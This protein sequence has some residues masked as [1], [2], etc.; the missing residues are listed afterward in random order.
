MSILT[1]IK[2]VFSEKPSTDFKKSYSQCGEDM[3]IDY[4]FKLRNIE[5][6]TY[7]DIGANDPYYLSNT[8]YFY[9]KG[10][11]GI[12][13]EA[14]PALIGRFQSERS[15]DINLNVGI[16]DKEG[17]A[18][19]FI[20]EDNTLSSFSKEDVDAMVAQ[21]KK[22]RSVKKINL[23]TLTKIIEENCDGNY[24]DFMSI[25]V[26]GLDFE[27]LKT[28]NYDE[29]AP[30]VI[31]VE[32]AEFSPVGAG[33]R[34][35]ELIDFLAGK[36]YY[37]YANTNLNAIM[38]RRDFWFIENRPFFS[39]IV[40]TYNSALHINKCVE[41]LISQSFKNF[42]VLIIDGL[43]TDDTVSKIESYKDK[44]IKIL[45]EP[46]KGIYD[47]MN[48]GI[49]LASGQWLLFLG[50]D[51]ELYDNNVLSAL[52][53][54]TKD[55]AYEVIYGDVLLLGET[56]WG[57]KGQ[58][59][60]G[61][62]DLEKLLSHNIAHQAIIYRKVIFGKYGNY[63][64]DFK[65]CADHDFNLRVSSRTEYHYINKIIT[66]FNAGGASSYKPDDEFNRQKIINLEKYFGRRRLFGP[67]FKQLR[68]LI[69]QQAREDIKHFRILRAAFLGT[70]SIYFKLR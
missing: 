53:S 70:L 42:E 13:I 33:R 8:A 49:R 60:D 19:F 57:H 9:Q 38:V 43:S 50:S 14:N 63:N 24:P 15:E 67:E 39:V 59:Y 44:R 64:E 37:E 46:D 4:V 20:M 52:H 69:W 36:G 56:G 27:I 11:R 35:D 31:C 7:L 3:I 12:N 1:K 28:L 48:K 30:K 23:T 40:P 68:Q 65:I 5:K 66:K 54:V 45:S 21:G 18:D 16:A 6:P 61:K 58:I 51:D 32:A 47:A 22:L 29:K 41:S 25:D 2:R 10:C 26:E 62:F 34:R 55:T 17:A